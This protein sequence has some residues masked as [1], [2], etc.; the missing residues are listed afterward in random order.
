MKYIG[1]FLKLI[2]LFSL[3]IF[4][5]HPNTKSNPTVA[6]NSQLHALGYKD[7]DIYNL[8]KRF[9]PSQLDFIITSQIS[10]ECLFPYLNI[11]TFQLSQIDEYE[12]IRTSKNISHLAAVNL[13]H[14][15]YLAN[16]FYQHSNKAFNLDSNLILVNKNYALDANFVPSNLVFTK[17]LRLLV[18]DYSRYYLQKEAYT[19]L[20]ALFKEAEKNNL[21][22]YLSN[23]YRS[24]QKQEKIYQQYTVLYEN[25]DLFSARPGHS[26]HQTGLAVDIT[27]KSVDYLLTEKIAETDE[28]KFLKHNAHRFGFI[29]RYPQ[30]KTHITGYS[31]EPWHL[32]YVGKKV[33]KIIYEN[34]LTL[35]E[36]LI[37][38]TVIPI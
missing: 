34:N 24:Y 29:E 15:P 6:P 17:D 36:Y 28:G 21:I 11:Y 30:D 13:T 12:M 9:S 4:I 10:R 26:E 35:E 27:C 8:K 14:H 31:Y 1:K 33:A 37:H 2:I 22:F 38:Y 25:A 16:D 3:I 7:E 18:D 5:S 32:R 20:K 19:A 23:G